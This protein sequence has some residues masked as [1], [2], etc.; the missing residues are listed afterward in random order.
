MNDLHSPPDVIVIPRGGV[1]PEVADLNAA[2]AAAHWGVPVVDLNSEHREFQPEM[3]GDA[4]AVALSVRSFALQE[5]QAI[6]ARLAAQARPPVIGSLRGP[7]DVLCCYRYVDLEARFDAALT[8]GDHLPDPGFDRFDNEGGLADAW[9]S[10]RFAYPIMTSLGC[11]YGCRFCAAAGRRWAPR[12]PA[13]CADELRAAAD[14]WS[15]ASFSVMDDVFNHD[16]DRTLAFCDAVAPLGLSWFC[17]NGLRADRFDPEVARE[18]RA[19]GCRHVS[20]GVETTDEAI[21]RAIRKGEK[22]E[23]IERAIAAS[24]EAG[25]PA[26]GFFLIGLP[27]STF[28][29]DMASLKWA[30]SQRITPHFSYFVPEDAFDDGDTR[31]WG[32]DS[33]PRSD[34]YPAEQQEQVYRASRRGGGLARKIVDNTLFTVAGR[35]TS[36]L[37]MIVL[38]PYIVARIGTAGFGVWALVSA[39]TGYVGLL[40]FGFRDSFVKH[41]A[42]AHT[43]GDDEGLARIVSS[44]LAFF[45]V[46]T[47]PVLALGFVLTPLAPG[48]LDIPPQLVHD[49]L[50]VFAAAVL[51]VVGINIVSVFE[52]VPLGLQRMALPNA[53]NVLAVLAQAVGTV[54]VLE[55]GF[56]LPGLAVNSL[57][58]LALRGTLMVLVVRRVAGG[59]RVATSHVHRPTVSKLARFGVQRWVAQV[60][61]ILSFQTDKLLLSAFVG[62]DAVGFYQ[63]GYLIAD[64]AS[65]LPRLLNSA[66]VPAASELAVVED[67]TTLGLIYIRGMRYV[68][69]IAAPLFLFLAATSPQILELWMGP[70]FEES[71]QVLRVFAIAL[72][73]VT[74]SS[75][76]SAL[77]LGIGRPDVQMKVGAVQLVANVGLS[78]VL[79]TSMGFLGPIVATLITMSI[80][81]I[82]FAAISNRQFGATWWHLLRS[83]VLPPLFAAAVPAVAVLLVVEHGSPMGAGRLTAL[84]WLLG[85]GV[86]FASVFASLALVTGALKGEDRALI[87]RLVLRRA[88]ALFPRRF[89]GGSGAEE[90]K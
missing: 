73:I 48:V 62:V 8:F 27:G 86:A 21:L 18:M 52:S 10:G 34:A 68:F 38:T 30:R 36:V 76:G 64:R 70:G 59:I 58:V 41:V 29:I 33:A 53:V 19:A 75:T 60:E 89:A 47:I 15:I 71:N 56:G 69:L 22:V 24:H 61:E 25:L 2:Y 20:F 37:V 5:A 83:A 57:A 65:L 44:A 88:R 72:L 14:R 66:V 13:G 7:I 43:R 50:V 31:F 85:E 77:L 40:D 81:S 49:A 80:S 87:D 79:V 11:P 74:L 12:S 84:I 90:E 42:E 32:D 46:W 39:I 28:E 23:D 3:V 51:M 9:R 35:F 78:L 1:N 45:A 4:G 6:E 63:L 55:S 17:N 67:R 82:V 16:R 26:A 54:L